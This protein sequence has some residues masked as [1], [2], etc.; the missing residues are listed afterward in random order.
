MYSFNCT[1]SVCNNFLSTSESIFPTV[2]I[3][4]TSSLAPFGLPVY[5]TCLYEEGCYC[6]AL[7]NLQLFTSAIIEQ[8]EDLHWES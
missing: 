7:Y 4:E 2:R 1:R 6:P 3:R 5:T 8:G